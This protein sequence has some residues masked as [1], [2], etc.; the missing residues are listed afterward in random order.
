MSDIDWLNGCPGRTGEVWN[1]YMGCLPEGKGCN[2]CCALESLPRIIS[3]PVCAAHQGIARKTPNGNWVWSG[4]VNLNEK[5][6]ELPYQWRKPR[7]VFNEFYGDPFFHG[8]P[9]AYQDMVATIMVDTQQHEYLMLSKNPDRAV[10][11]WLWRLS[12]DMAAPDNVWAG[13]SIYDQASADA[14]LPHMHTL[15]NLGFKI[16][17]S[18]EPMLGPIVLPRWV[19]EMGDRAWIII[20]GQSAKRRD[21]ATR[22]EAVWVY[23]IL[24][25]LVNT[26]S[27]VYFKQ[28]GEF[29]E[30]GE[31][32]GKAAAGHLVWGEFAYRDFPKSMEVRH[33]A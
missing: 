23:D 8:V 18:I 13:V 15:A 11:F 6:L 22:M 27:A 7:L 2:P 5:A 28:W 19:L 29:N 24:D 17:I 4:K 1:P 32:V 10:E 25:Q 31:L 3:N 30:Q 20:G 9:Q 14:F 21:Q 16:V 26:G 12:D 33:A